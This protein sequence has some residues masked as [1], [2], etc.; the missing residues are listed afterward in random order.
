MVDDGAT[1]SRNEQLAFVSGTVLAGGALLVKVWPILTH[2]QTGRHDTFMAKRLSDIAP[3]AV[4]CHRIG[5][6][7]V[8]LG[9]GMLLFGTVHVIARGL[10]LTE[11][12][13]ANTSKSGRGA[14][15]EIARRAY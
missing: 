1:D 14:S 3:A 12:Q 6:L 4:V 7:I 8:A 11:F 2:M 15:D 10:S 9:L 5:C 13:L